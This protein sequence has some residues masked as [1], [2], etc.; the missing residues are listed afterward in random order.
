LQHREVDPI[1]PHVYCQPVKGDFIYHVKR[2]QFFLAA[3]REIGKYPTVVEW[4]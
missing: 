4:P 3:K 2:T 1:F